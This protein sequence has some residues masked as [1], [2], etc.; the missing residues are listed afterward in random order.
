MILQN[1]IFQS[2]VLSY[3]YNIAFFLTDALT[4]QQILKDPTNRL[5]FLLLLNNSQLTVWSY[6]QKMIKKKKKDSLSNS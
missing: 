2:V 6:F 5:L 4:C 3:Y 1:G